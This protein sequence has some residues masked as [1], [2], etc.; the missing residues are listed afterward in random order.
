M[1]IVIHR[2]LGKDPFRCVGLP[3][4]LQQQPRGLVGGL[5]G[6]M[7]LK[8]RPRRNARQTSRRIRRHRH[9][10]RQGRCHG[11]LDPTSRERGEVALLGGTQNQG[12]GMMTKS[13]DF[14]GTRAFKIPL[15]PISPELHLCLF[16]GHDSFQRKGTRR[17]FFQ[18]QVFCLGNK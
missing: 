13:P 7:Q 18:L 15:N 9:I 4:R 16:A 1:T 2:S 11:S 12:R 17:H 3:Q 6:D 8:D 5:T 10:F 14:A